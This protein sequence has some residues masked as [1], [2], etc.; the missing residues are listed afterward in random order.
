[1]WRG[2]AATVLGLA[3]AALSC[4]REDARSES[5]GADTGTAEVGLGA[6]RSDWGPDKK[7]AFE[8]GRALFVRVFT[9]E[10]GLGPGFNDRSCVACHHVPVAAGGGDLANAVKLL[11]DPAHNEIIP[12]PAHQTSG[13]GLAPPL[14]GTH[15]TVFASP[16]LLGLGFIDE[17]PGEELRAA[18][19][20]HP[21]AADGVVGH[22]N[23][24]GDGAIGK[25]GQKA[26]VASLRRFVEAALLGE[27]GLTSALAT[28]VL[29]DDDGTADPEVSSG[30]AD[31]FATFLAGLAPPP[32][33]PPHEGSAVFTT[34]GCI[35]CHSTKTAGR[36]IGAYSDFCVHAM[37]PEFDVGA[38]DHTALGDE[39]RSAPLWGI[40]YRT[41]FLHDLRA[42]TLD[43]AIRAH[44]GEAK[45]TRER[46]EILDAPTRA[47]LLEFVSRL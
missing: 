9:P 21:F 24:R 16:P 12:W 17:I 13:G 14:P 30:E 20:V 15:H 23:I 29:H 39:F 10:V 28:D 33:A 27:L 31:D 19:D 18:C 37:G 7:V 40:R 45:R 35:A 36:E 3:V 46:Y 41:R 34:V 43:E 8:R 44:G 25:F 2:I 1:M 32:A 6:M 4:K 22:A 38:R 42:T 11:V 47:R 5:R 26:N